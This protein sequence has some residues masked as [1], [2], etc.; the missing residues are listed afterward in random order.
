MPD[1]VLVRGLAAGE[2]AAVK[3]AWRRFSDQVFRH[4]RRAF[5]PAYDID[6]LAQEVFVRL[7]GAVRKLQRAEALPAFVTAVTMR[8][9]R[10]E[11]TRRHRR[12][13]LTFITTTDDH[14]SL[15][16][17]FDARDA[18]KRVYHLLDKFDPESRTT[19]VLRHIEE[20]ELTEVAA[21]VETSLATVKRRL[22]RIEER[23]GVLVERDP[24]LA[25]YRVA[26]TFDGRARGESR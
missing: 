14:A 13:W 21:A 26:G 12:R 1:D 7:L 22:A 23:F 10:R 9:V 25:R 16:V 11:L 2:A 8:V 6:D 24:V 5:G 17:D 4:L 19:F 18:L 15:G 3:E 20:M